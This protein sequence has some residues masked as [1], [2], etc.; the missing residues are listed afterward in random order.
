M[1]FKVSLSAMLLVLLGSGVLW[2]GDPWKEKPYT[3]WTKKEVGKVL[4]KSPWAKQV[5]RHARDKLILTTPPTTEKRTY[6]ALTVVWFSALPVREAFERMRQL[7][8]AES[9]REDRTGLSRQPEHYEV[10]VFEESGGRFAWEY[11]DSPHPGSCYLQPKR[12]K[13]T[14]S[15]VRVS[16]FLSEIEE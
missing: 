13:Q 12:S 1:K 14:I 11:S 3:E 7:E 6:H 5:K 2:A 15:P 10:M 8:G 9:E 4:V 16:Q